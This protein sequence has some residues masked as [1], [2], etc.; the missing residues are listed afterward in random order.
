MSARKSSTDYFLILYVAFIAKTATSLNSGHPTR[1][2]S[3]S[4]DGR[5][6]TIVWEAGHSFVADITKTDCGSNAATLAD[7]DSS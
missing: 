1:L 3:I 5:T 2:S 6:L 4:E 7:F